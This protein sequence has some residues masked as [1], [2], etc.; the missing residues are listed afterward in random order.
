MS[1]QIEIIAGVEKDLMDLAEKTFD[2]HDQTTLDSCWAK[3]KRHN[4]LLILTPG[5]MGG[6]WCAVVPPDKFDL[7]K[8]KIPSNRKYWLGW[9]L[10]ALTWYI[11][12]SEELINLLIEG[13]TPIEGNAPKETKGKPNGKSTGKSG[14]SRKSGATKGR[15]TKGASTKPRGGRSGTARKGAA[16]TSHNQ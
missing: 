1:R 6:T 11:F 10:K 12:G 2:R 4:H 9:N 7:D 15:S 16:Q 13:N 3:A 8:R 5:G 14:T